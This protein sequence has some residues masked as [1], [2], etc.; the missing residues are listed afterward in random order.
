[1]RKKKAQPAKIKP[2]GQRK[3]SS[4]RVGYIPPSPPF[5]EVFPWT[6]TY[7]E[8]K[9]EKFCCFQDKS[10]V[11]KYIERYKLRSNNY[12]IT[13]TKPKTRDILSILKDM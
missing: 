9:E 11:E 4:Q 13:K 12:K 2:I 1:M 3:E 7:M 10:H 8:G 6:L 5:H